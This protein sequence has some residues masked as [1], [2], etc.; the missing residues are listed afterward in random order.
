MEPW[1]DR[2]VENPQSAVKTADKAGNIVPPGA[3]NAAQSPTQPTQ[4][5]DA[6]AS[7]PVLQPFS[8]V[9]IMTELPSVMDELCPEGVYIAAERASHPSWSPAQNIP[10]L[11]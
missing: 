4:V 2:A 6:E 7:P 9:A 8:P 5:A 3:E 11:E 10:Q 1:A